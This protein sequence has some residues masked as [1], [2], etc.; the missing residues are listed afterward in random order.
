MILKRVG[1]SGQSTTV[2]IDAKNKTKTVETSLPLLPSVVEDIIA[3]NF[4][5]NIAMAVK[6]NT[7]TRLVAEDNKEMVIC[8]RSIRT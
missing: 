1:P 7:F 4:K 6:F 2:F 3:V 8:I 5:K